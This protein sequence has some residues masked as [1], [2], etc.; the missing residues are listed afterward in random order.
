[1][2]D[3]GAEVEIP[4][5]TLEIGTWVEV[6]GALGTDGLLHAEELEAAGEHET[7]L[8]ATLYD[9]TDTNFM[10]I[11]LTI[12]YDDTLEMECEEDED[13]D[14]DDDHHDDDEGDD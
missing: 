6:E 9:L 11:G 2:L 10:M 1:M 12:A 8:T 14:D 4:I 5:E 13:D 7:E 3:A